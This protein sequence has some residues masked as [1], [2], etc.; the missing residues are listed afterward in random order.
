M[1]RY[2][3][4]Q[5]FEE[6]LIHD[7]VWVTN[8]HFM[9]K[10]D[11]LT[12]TQLNYVNKFPMSKDTINQLVK[13]VISNVENKNSVTEF[14]AQQI[15]HTV[16]PMLVFN[17]HNNKE[18]CLNSQYYHFIQGR[19]CTVHIT[20]DESLYSPMNIYNKN[21]EFVGIVLPVKTKEDYDTMD[22]N[23]WLEQKNNKPQ[24]KLMKP[25]FIN[26]MYNREGKRIRAN[27]L[28]TVG[29][30]P[31]WIEDGKPNKDYGKNENDK[32]YLYIQVDEW[33]VMTGYTEYE[34]M[35]RA[36]QDHLNKEWYGDF[37]GRQKY[38][39]EN[40]Y[41]GR[42]YEEYNPLI[43]EHI[44]KEEVFIE[45]SGENETIQANYIKT[46]IDKAIANYIEARDNNGKFADF[47]GAAFLDELDKC[48]QIA[49]VLKTKRQ[50]KELER[51]RELA[52]QRAKEA[53]E[54][55]LAEKLLM[56]ETEQILINGG[57]VKGGEIIVKIAD[58]Y[59]INIPLRTRGWILNNLAETTIT[60]G[61]SVSYKYFKRSKNAT[62]SQKVYDVLFDIRRVLK[63]A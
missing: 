17:T 56:E 35:Q 7:D 6:K 19:K 55:A 42:T 26:G 25:L 4:K 46:F 20:E 2:N 58:K 22:Y 57:T 1:A 47:I 36:G 41:K 38:F 50:E 16:D 12:K 5:F 53:E 37:E 51:K 33:L 30:Y 61:G 43:K 8:S 28:K 21:L 14:K 49:K 18:Y 48:E 52:E 9:I 31:L 60:D 40:F 44:E 39:E 34:L 11:I 45:E 63:S 29:E 15:A 3:F 13:N 32:Y 54:K 62:G 59:N 27:Y 10:K 24:A 23:S